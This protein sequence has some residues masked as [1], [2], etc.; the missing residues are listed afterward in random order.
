MSKLSRF[1][2]SKTI[3]NKLVMKINLV[4]KLPKLVLTDHK[5]KFLGRIDVVCLTKINNTLN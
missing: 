3:L 2:Q 1:T 5:N 4:S